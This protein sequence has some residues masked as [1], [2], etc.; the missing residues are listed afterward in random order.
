MCKSIVDREPI[1]CD[2]RCIKK[3]RDMRIACAFGTEKDFEENKSHYKFEYYPED[4]IEFAV[5]NF[6]WAKKV[7]AQLTY[8]VLN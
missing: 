1:D 5:H 7:E 2:A 6:A 8:I 3:Q 4:A